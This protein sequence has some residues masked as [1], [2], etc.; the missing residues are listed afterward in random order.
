MIAG[1]E[2]MSYL[3]WFRRG[4]VSE[5]RA[6]L[7]PALVTHG[8]RLA[9]I[10]VPCGAC[11]GGSRE[12]MTLSGRRVKCPRCKGTGWVLNTGD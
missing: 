10:D 1:R 7:S 9:R 12:F 8:R 5:A 2:W 4:F 6:A 3:P 11:K